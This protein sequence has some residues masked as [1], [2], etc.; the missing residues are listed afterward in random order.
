MQL[1]DGFHTPVMRRPSIKV[2]LRFLLYLLDRFRFGFRLR[3]RLRFRS[4]FRLRFRLWFGSRFRLRFR[5]RSRFRLRS[6]QQL[7]IE[8]CPIRAENDFYDISL[9]REISA[10]Y[11][12]L[13]RDLQSACL[14]VCKLY[15]AGTLVIPFQNGSCLLK[16]QIFR[17]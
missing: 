2:F 4:R 12:G 5:S 7:Y 10:G 13:I 1:H 11:L 15:F 14:A 9:F 6:L 17:I 8:Q 16:L 3:F